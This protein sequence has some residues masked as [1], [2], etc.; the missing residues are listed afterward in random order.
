MNFAVTAEQAEL[1]RSARRFLASQCGSARVR[2]A[3]ESERGID[4]DAWRQ[5]IELGWAALAVPEVLGGAGLGWPEVAVLAEET[6]RSLACVPFFS[7]VCL[8]VNALLAGFPEPAR[9]H[10]ERIAACET[11]ATLAFAEDAQVDAL[12]IATTAREEQGGF[13]LSGTKRFVVDAQ[14]ADLLLVTARAPGSSGADGVSIFAIPAGAPGLKCRLT[15]TLDATRRM[16]TVELHD[17]RVARAA[18]TG[19]AAAL[20]RMLDRA[21]VALAAE[22]LGGAERCL[23]MATE[24]AKTRVQFDRPIGSFQAI[25]HA[26]A[27]LFVAVESA[28]SAVAWAASVAGA[29]T[30]SDLAVAAALAKSYATEAFFR[31]AAGCIQV[32]GGIGFTWEHDAHLFLKRARGSLAL[33]GSPAQDRERIARTALALGAPDAGEQ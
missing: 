2:V 16:S 21:A 17:V 24:Y 13:V 1:R 14:G 33:L 32:L 4:D 8:G 28:R 18:K 30:E 19:D 12:A 10:L 22:S 11:R 26:L 9:A 15:P 5:A 31:C 20:R 29:G 6:G 3:M 27:D 25:K 7:T 23:E